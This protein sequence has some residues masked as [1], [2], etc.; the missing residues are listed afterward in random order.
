MKT[1]PPEQYPTLAQLINATYTDRV[2]QILTAGFDDNDNILGVALDGS[3]QIAFEIGDNNKIKIRLVNPTEPQP[4]IQAQFSEI[5]DPIN[6]ILDQLK[7]IGDATF[8]D[9]F[10]NLQSL[11]QDSGDL[12]DF[13]AKL[14]DTFPDLNAAEFKQAM[15]DASVVAGMQGYSDAQ[16][17][18]GG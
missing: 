2:E 1:I 13:Q 18:S 4:S 11:M 6:P 15:L 5:V 9:W 12:T 3:K 16:A 10:T 17:Q 14:T 8:Q 7:P